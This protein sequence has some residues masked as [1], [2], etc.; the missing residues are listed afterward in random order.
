M[1]GVLVDHVLKELGRDF[2]GL[3]A[4]LGGARLLD[5]Q[6]GA[7]SGFIAAFG[8]PI[9]HR[10]GSAFGSIAIHH[11]LELRDRL[12]QVAATEID[13]SHHE[14]RSGAEFVALFRRNF[15]I[16]FQRLIILS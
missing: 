11:A 5:H 9:T 15:L 4:A 3:L 14:S 12:D 7:A 13:L 10:F 6:L 1:F 16:K 2:S 8:L